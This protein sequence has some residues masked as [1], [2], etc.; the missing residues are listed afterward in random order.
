MSLIRQ[1]DT[2]WFDKFKQILAT[3]ITTLNIYP[4]NPLWW[5]E[6]K[7][8]P[9]GQKQV[10]PQIRDPN[11][12]VHVSKDVE[13]IDDEAK[14]YVQVA[15]MPSITKSLRID[16]ELYAGDPVNALGHVGDL[17]QYFVDGLKQFGIAGVA[18]PAP[19]SYGL[20]DV[21][22]GT[23]STTVTRPDE[24]VA[25]TTSGEWDTPVQLTETLA[26]M[27]NTL[28]A[29]GF[30]GPRVIGAHPLVRPFLAAYPMANTSVP[31]G[32]YITTGFGYQWDLCEW[33]DADATKDVHSI[34][35]IDSTAFSLY[36]TPMTMRAF[37]DPRT[38]H[39]YW[40]WKTRCV[41]L[42][43]PKNNGTD[44]QKGIVRCVID[45]HD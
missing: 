35:M 30:H 29:G 1:W 40:R 8:I 18:G 34:Y 16:E 38:E 28:A 39:Y 32:S 26:E 13:Y 15:D 3:N 6:R 43:K 24:L 10:Q 4:G 7:D 33:Y 21:G 11:D 36:Q 9:F 42:A 44:W 41:M 14:R 25:V 5:C 37:W 17:G 45:I 31:L 2:D 27:E 12:R 23:G 20:I 22:A 19:T